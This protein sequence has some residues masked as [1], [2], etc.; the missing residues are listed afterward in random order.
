MDGDNNLIVGDIITAYHKG[1]H[2][3]T[4]IRILKD[5]QCGDQVLVEYDQL[6]TQNGK[7]RSGH[8]VCNI[9]YC[10]RITA[11]EI[12][13]QRA[14]AIKEIDDMYEAVLNILEK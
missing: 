7:K 14:I 2:K 9:G 12:A 1:F 8:N 5:S 10:K 6:L 13:R 4:N 11:E 3:I